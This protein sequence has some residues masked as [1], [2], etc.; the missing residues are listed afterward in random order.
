MIKR[1]IDIIGSALG[2]VMLAGPMLI[3]S[4]LIRMSSPGPAI[5]RQSRAGK[6]G[7]CFEMLKFRTM[8][9]D[10]DPYGG[11][12]N[13]ADDPRLTGIG[14]FLRE[15]SLDEL[16]QLVNVFIGQ[17]SLVGP[18]PLYERQAMEWNARQRRRLEVRPGMTGY[19]QV[20]G[21]ALL[22]HEDKIELDVYYVENICL[23]LDLKILL[24]TVVGL[25]A[26]QGQIYER[27]YSQAKQTEEKSEH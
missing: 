25:F 7:K 11:S 23:S 14:R 3:I 21:R 20:Y 2:M 5:F 26:G 6:N 18:R 17:M 24:K 12:P 27:R 10:C 13:A 9:A 19:A 16:P 1:T 15:K 8:R 4:I 22:T